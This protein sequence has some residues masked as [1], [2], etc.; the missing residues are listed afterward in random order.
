MAFTTGVLII[1]GKWY[2]VHRNNG[3][4]VYFSAIEPKSDSST[5]ISPFLPFSSE[6]CLNL[7][8]WSPA[9]LSLGRVAS[10]RRI[11]LELLQA[12][13]SCSRETTVLQAA[14]AAEVDFR[15]HLSHESFCCLPHRS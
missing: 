7:E 14:A 15:N 11:E 4:M 9:V 3:E 6:V 1:T 13:A 8:P 5:K 12:Q 10:R 2:V